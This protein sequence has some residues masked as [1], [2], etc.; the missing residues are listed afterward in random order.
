MM[1]FAVWASMR[2]QHRASFWRELGFINA[3]RARNSL[4]LL[5]QRHWPESYLVD[6][7]ADL[8]EDSRAKDSQSLA[9]RKKTK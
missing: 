1:A 5:S 9:H 8:D 4:W 3:R 6:F 7:M 2:G